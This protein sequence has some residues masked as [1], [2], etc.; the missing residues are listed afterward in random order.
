LQLKL[1][2][3]DPKQRTLFPCFFAR[4]PVTPGSNLFSVAWTRL[5]P[6]TE[7]SS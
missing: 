2:K 1:A 3:M 4:R 7:S 6:F 5:F